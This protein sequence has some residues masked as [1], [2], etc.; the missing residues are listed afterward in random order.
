[1][2]FVYKILFGLVI[3]NGTAFFMLRYLRYHKY[4]I[5]KQRSVDRIRESF[6]SVTEWL[7]YETIYQ[8][9]QILQVSIEMYVLCIS[10][11]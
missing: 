6:C 9:V 7:I 3:S 1:M 4:V 8:F 10:T 11:W 5:V 2:L